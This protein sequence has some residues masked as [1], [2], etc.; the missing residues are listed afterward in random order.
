MTVTGHE[1]PLIYGLSQDITCNVTGMEMVS[2]TWMTNVA[3]YQ[4]PIVSDNNVSVLV[5]SLAPEKN[6]NSRLDCSN[7]LCVAIGTDGNRYELS[8][9]IQVKGTHACTQAL[10]VGVFI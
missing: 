9:K 1:E 2:M 4:V 8:I 10:R 7:F 6:S 5:L 3:G